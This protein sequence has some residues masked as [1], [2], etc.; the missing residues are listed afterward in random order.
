MTHKR[1]N[2]VTRSVNHIKGA[3][4]SLKWAHNEKIPALWI[5]SRNMGVCVPTMRKAV[6]ILMFDKI[7]ENTG[8]GFI[9]IGMPKARVSTL[10][11]AID[12]VRFNLK[13]AELLNRGAVYDAATMSIFLRTAKTIEIIRPL[14]NEYGKFLAD[15]VKKALDTPITAKQA[16]DRKSLRTAYKIQ[17]KIKTFMDIITKNKE[18]LGLK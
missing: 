15:G 5:L 3:I 10:R 17:C 14:S 13:S 7:L 16:S 1:S 11:K 12:D 18:K 8:R 2:E 4:K 6:D 9:V